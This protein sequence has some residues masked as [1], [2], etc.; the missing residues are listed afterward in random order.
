MGE[1]VVHLSLAEADALGRRALTASLT[2]EE[3]A[4]STVRALVNAEADGQKG[5][6]VSR[7]PSYAEQAVA[8]KVN[9]FAEPRLEQL[10][11][12]AL[13]VDA[14]RG[15]AYPAID[16]AVAALAPMARDTGVA[17]AAIHRSHHFGQAGAHAERLAEQGLVALVFGNSPKGIAFWGSRPPALG[18]NP[19]AFAAPLG[20]APP[21]VIDLA[22]SVAARGKI[23]AAQRSGR[24][25]PEDWAYDEHGEPTT[26][27]A[28]ALAG[29]MAPI[30]G[31]KGA[32]LALM[33]EILAAAVTGSNFGFEASSLFDSKGEAPKLGQMILTLDPDRLSGGGF[34]ARMATL[35][36]AIEQT[37]GARLPGL[38]RLEHRARAKRDGIDVPGSLHRRLLELVAKES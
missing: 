9:G 20:E 10:T 36:G 34:T 4:A 6:G 30:G 22:M 1:D 33:V 28:A 37:E 21:L 15:F 17:A 2:S 14:S 38:M 32:T 24:E 5:H 23:I 25:I 13:R 8:G 7:I 16:L 18:T 27:P 3:N 11:P 35:V 29:S 19:I 31:V 12:S 26:D